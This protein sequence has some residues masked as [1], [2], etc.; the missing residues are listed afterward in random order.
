MKNYFKTTL[1][2]AL[3]GGLFIALGYVLFGAAGMLVG[4]AMGLIMS[5]LSWFKSDK[6]A[7]RMAKAKPVT[8][9]QLPQYYEI[10][11]ELAAKADMPMPDLYITPSPQPNAFATGRNPEHAAVAITQG[12]LDHLSW[13]EIRGVL[14]HE[15]SHVRHRDI[16]ISSVAAAI[17]M[18]ITFAVYFVMIFGGGSRRRG[19]G[20]G[21]VLLLTLILAPMAAAIIQGALSRNR[22]YKADSGAATLIGTG[23]PLARALEKLNAAADRIPAPEV[24]AEQAAAYIVNPLRGRKVQFANLF[25]THPPAEERISRLR[26]GEWE[27]V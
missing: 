26:S 10:M 22:E 13:D 17:A 6:L 15:L 12:L 1:L 20:N 24:R 16:L 21:L 23:E 2:L 7:I 19:G 27:T 3:L 25:S 8:R 9:E 11:E 4:L 14:A 5:G 18:A